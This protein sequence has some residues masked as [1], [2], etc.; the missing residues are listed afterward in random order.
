MCEESEVRRLIGWFP[1]PCGR[2]PGEVRVE[3]KQKGTFQGGDVSA[4]N[5][6]PVQPWERERI[7]HTQSQGCGRSRGL[8][9][10]TASLAL[11]PSLARR[12]PLRTR[13][14]LAPGKDE[15]RPGTAGHHRRT[16]EGSGV[17]VWGGGGGREEV[18]AA[19]SRLSALL[20]LSAASFPVS[21]AS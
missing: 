8:S 21:Q 2:V 20:V 17:C 18:R 11:P 16:A 3:L 4:Q 7:P 14:P 12:D 1:L 5:T 19:R 13:V 9:F 15:G 10:K 6:A